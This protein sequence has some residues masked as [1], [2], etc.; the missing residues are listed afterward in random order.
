MGGF[1]NSFNL[2]KTFVVEIQ[3]EPPKNCMHQLKTN[4]IYV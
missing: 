3:Q 1:N 2:E 4:F